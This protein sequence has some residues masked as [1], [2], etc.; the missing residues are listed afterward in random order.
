M[1]TNEFFTKTLKQQ[2]ESFND[3]MKRMDEYYQ[4]QL[5]EKQAVIDSL[6]LTTI[7]DGG[8]TNDTNGNESE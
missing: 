5:A 7:G 3:N 4:A 6:I 2:Q 8:T 1:V